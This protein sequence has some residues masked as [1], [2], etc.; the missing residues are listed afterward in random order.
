ME[1]ERKRDWADEAAEKLVPKTYDDVEAHR[2]ILAWKASVTDEVRK[3]RTRTTV[4]I[5]SCT[6][7]E[8][9]GWS[10]TIRQGRDGVPLFYARRS[11]KMTEMIM[12]GLRRT[13]KRR[14]EN[15]NGQ[16]E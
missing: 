6:A 9:D 15:E 11:W 1:Q 10:V 3:G 12:E 16:S 5:G 14:T 2:A 8:R 13:A 4:R 7:V